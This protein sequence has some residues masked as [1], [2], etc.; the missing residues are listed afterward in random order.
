MFVFFGFSFCF[1][2]CNVIITMIVNSCVNLLML[3]FCMEL[4]TDST[5]CTQK[6]CVKWFKWQSQERF[7]LNLYN[8]LFKSC[9]YINFLFFS[10]R[11]LECIK[12]IFLCGFWSWGQQSTEFFDTHW[13]RPSDISCQYSRSIYNARFIVWQPRRA[14]DTSTNWRK[15]LFCCCTACMEQA[16]DGA[17]IAA[18]NGLISSWS[19]NISVSFCLQAPGYWLTLWCTLGLPVVVTIQVPQLQLQ[20]NLKNGCK[21]II[22]SAP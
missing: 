15:S 7:V 16:A 4:I 13:S 21:T 8:Q 18:I 17:K 2:E 1:S 3:W 9:L 6:V 11:G 10:P 14:V 22:H 12:Y 20:I 19:E 5:S